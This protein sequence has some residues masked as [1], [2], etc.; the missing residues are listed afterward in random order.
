MGAVTLLRSV[1]LKEGAPDEG[2]PWDLP[3]VR[4]VE[5]LVPHP[6]VTFLVGDNGTGKSTLVEAMA[7]VAG[8]NAE[9]GNR[10]FQFSSA[11]RVSVTRAPRAWWNPPEKGWFL[12]AESFY[13]VATYID[14]NV[15][16]YFGARSFHDRSH[17]QSFIDL[18]LARFH[19]GGFYLLDEPEAALSFQGCLRM[20]RIIHDTVQGGGQFVIATH[21][22]VLLAYPDAAIFQLSDAGIEERSYDDVDAVELW[23]DFLEAPDRFLRHLLADEDDED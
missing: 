12:R 7:V 14:D 6:K 11:N 13:N 23:R 10:N 9:G 21:S 20:L 22:P 3:A 15:S 8:F 5:A 16:S 1:R 2:Y 17:G 18:A 19:P 4:F